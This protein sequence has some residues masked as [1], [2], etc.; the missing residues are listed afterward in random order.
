MLRLHPY[1]YIYFNRLI[2]GGQQVASRQFETEYWGLSYKEGAEWLL[3]NY[4]PA[5]TPVR[6]AMCSP[7]R[8]LSGYFIEASDKGRRDFRLVGLDQ[9]PEV[10]LAN[11]RYGCHRSVKGDVVHVV[12]RTG[13]PFLY[14]IRT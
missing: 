1:E 6:V 9:S 12:E 8:F 4:Q 10:V 5:S 7:E 3:R 13:A 14:V 11:T 2:A